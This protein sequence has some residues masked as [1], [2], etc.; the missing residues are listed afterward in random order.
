MRPHAR[1]LAAHVQAA[2][3]GTVQPR[4]A[5]PPARRLAPHVQAA[6]A[7]TA[8]P[9][10]PPRGAVARPTLPVSP[11]PA[12]AG[13]NGAVQPAFLSGL[14]SIFSS[15]WPGGSGSREPTRSEDSKG[16]LLNEEIPSKKRSTS[17]YVGQ[18]DSADL[19]PRDTYFPGDLTACAMVFV[20]DNEEGCVYHW[21]FHTPS[22]SY[23]RELRTAMSSAGVTDPTRCLAFGRDY[24]LSNPKRK[25]YLESWAEFG[26]FVQDQLGVAPE[27]FLCEDQYSNP[28]LEFTGSSV[29]SRFPP[30]TG[31]EE[32]MG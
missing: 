1:A 30:F 3:A 23:L 28:I 8:Q 6:I 11:K 10:M 20:F 18:G 15:C 19:T 32:L 21:P 26:D 24:G 31:L 13:L 12:A 5:I 16:L 14:C 4:A 17:H 29:V 2:I 22:T 27:I 25:K 9:A 7:A